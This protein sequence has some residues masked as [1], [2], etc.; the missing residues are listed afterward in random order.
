MVGCFL[1]DEYGLQDIKNG[2]NPLDRNKLG[3]RERERER[4]F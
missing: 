4:E 2:G 1:V 3:E